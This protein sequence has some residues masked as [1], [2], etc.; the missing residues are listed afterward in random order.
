MERNAVGD[1]VQAAQRPE[2]VVVQY[3]EP[4][5]RNAQV[6]GFDVYSEPERRAALDRAR[7]TGQAVATKRLRLVQDMGEQPGLL[8]FVPVYDGM[9]P[10]PTLAQRRSELRGYAVG[11]FSSGELVA[12]ALQGLGAANMDVRLYDESDGTPILIS[13]YRF[14]ETGTGNLTS[15]PEELQTPSFFRYEAQLNVA[16]R[17][18]RLQLSADKAYIASR[19]TWAGW[20]ALVFGLLFS[21]LLGLLLLALTARRI[22]D[23][24]QTAALAETNRTLS[25][26]VAQRVRIEKALHAEKERVEVTLHSIGDAVISTDAQGVVE[27]MNPAAERLTA[28][29][30]DEARGRPVQE[31]FKV[32]N[33]ETRQPERNPV[34]RCLETGQMLELKRPLILISRGGQEYAI[35]DSVAP[36]RDPQERLQGAVL[37]FHDVTEAHRLARAAE[38]QANHDSLT[39]L[40]NRAEFE[41][42]VERALASCKQYGTQHALCYLDLDQFKVV[43]DTCGHRAGDVLLRGLT[44]LLANAVRDRDTLARLG[45][46]EFGLLLENCPLP[47]A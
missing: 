46:D 42:R 17:K 10:P 31:I 47:K 4:L 16:A 5:L 22:A 25:E 1:L 41:K 20:G 8:V 24:R 7:D 33:E 29:S 28:W 23:A 11:V 45:G 3:I 36:I 9:T 30:V 18:W 2:Y 12:G 14:D 39:G 34:E 40:V 13:A 26:E 15:S 44:G 43:N 19:R 35:A 38:Y 32:L 21:S 37:V 27:Y 6:L